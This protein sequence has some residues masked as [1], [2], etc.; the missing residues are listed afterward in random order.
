[1]GKIVGIIP[2]R[3]ASTR[4]P[5]KPLH[6]LSGKPLIQHVWERCQEAACLDETI[7]ATDDMRIAEAAFAFGAEVALTGDHHQSGTD[8]IAEVAEGLR[9]RVTHVINIQG[10]EPTISPALIDRL[11]STL[12]ENKSMEMIT[13]A[14]VL[15]NLTDLHNPN[16]VKVVLAK[17]GNALYFSRSVIPH[18]SGVDASGVVFYR[19]QGI[20]GYERRFLTR[21]VRWKPSDYERVE[22]LEQLR[23]LEHGAAVHVLITDHCSHGVDSP[24][25]VPQAEARLRAM[26]QEIHS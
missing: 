15:D 23:A 3:W 11:A 2:A 12:R 6:L 13:A 9:A 8:R 4:F 24:E 10:D 22:R 25:D 16:C 26:Q 20:Y 19:H 18:P 17:S 1:M 21:F 7:I 14:S 5:G